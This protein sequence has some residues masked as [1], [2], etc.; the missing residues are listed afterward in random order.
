MLVLIDLK[1]IPIILTSI[2]GPSLIIALRGQFGLKP[3]VRLV[4]DLIFGLFSFDLVHWVVLL[5][6][7]LILRL[8]SVL[9]LV[10]LNLVVEFADCTV[11]FFETCFESIKLC[12]DSSDSSIKIADQ[13]LNPCDVP[14]SSLIDGSVCWDHLWE[15]MENILLLHFDYT[16]VVG[17]LGCWL[18]NQA[19]WLAI[20]RQHAARS[21][22]NWT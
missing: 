5:L 18:V 9:G 21:Q 6:K 13:R 17:L 7:L 12:F 11:S 15:E 10:F 3:W 20:D 1:L 4:F 19:V 14:G 8:D 2:G 16:P 22:Q